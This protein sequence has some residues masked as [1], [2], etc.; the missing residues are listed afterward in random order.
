MQHQCLRHKEQL[1]E[2]A[3]KLKEEL[4]HRISA[5]VLNLTLSLVLQSDQVS[6]GQRHAAPLARLH[7]DTYKKNKV[8][9]LQEHKNALWNPIFN[10]KC[11]NELWENLEL[12]QETEE[13]AQLT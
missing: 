7:T 10:T 1:V 9:P 5:L 8:C 3:K 11:H 13:K 12:Q 6:A 2:A 4:R